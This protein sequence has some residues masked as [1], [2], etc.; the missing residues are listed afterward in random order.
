M[1]IL[2][3]KLLG[4]TLTQRPQRKFTRRKNTRHRPAPQARRST[5]KNQRAPLPRGLLLL[6]VILL[7]S[8]YRCTGERKR[9]GDAGLEGLLHI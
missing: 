8:K 5:R 2:L 9:P 4:Q 7:K 1:N 6:E 3:P